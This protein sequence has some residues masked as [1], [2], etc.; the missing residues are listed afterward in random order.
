MS[1]LFLLMFAC[2]D[3]PPA[4]PLPPEIPEMEQEKAQPEQIPAPFTPEQIREAMPKGRILIWQVTNEGKVNQQRWFVRAADEREV[5]LV[6]Q[7]Y[8]DVAK[9]MEPES[10][11]TAKWSDLR[12]HAVFP[13]GSTVRTEETVDLL[14][15]HD[16]FVYTVTDDV[17]V[18]NYWFAKD[19]PGPP[20]RH[21]IARDGAVVYE[22]LLT[23][24]ASR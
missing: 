23:K 20:I 19:M 2:A 7:D 17:G 5:T 11:L 1:A 8:S 10:V 14:G 13:P 16:C 6:I 3:P 4:T 12:D 9:T 15:Q 21:T 22:M 18:S 24:V